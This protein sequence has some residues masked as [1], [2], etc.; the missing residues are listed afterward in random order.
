[1][2]PSI[3]LKRSRV[4]KRR[5]KDRHCSYPF[6]VVIVDGILIAAI[7]YWQWQ[8]CTRP[9]YTKQNNRSNFATVVVQI[10]VIPPGLDRQSEAFGEAG[11]PL[12]IN[13]FLF[14]QPSIKCLTELRGT[15]CLQG[16]VFFMKARSGLHEH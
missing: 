15:T 4:V 8:A 12:K 5:K 7:L 3:Y 6:F 9:R 10:S 13:I 1:M 14:P 2:R 16:R 11:I